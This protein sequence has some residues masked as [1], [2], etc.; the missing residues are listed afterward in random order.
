MP[1]TPL[2]APAHSSIISTQEEH[3]LRQLAVEMAKDIANPPDILKALGFTPVE[4]EE[5]Q[6]TRAYKQMYAEALS[7]WASA[8]NTQ[9]RV[10]LKAAATIELIMHEFYQ[11]LRNRGEN[12]SARTELL[13]TIARIGGLGNP[14]PPQQR[15]SGQFFKLEIHI[16]GKEQPIIIGGEAYELTESPLASEEPYDEL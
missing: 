4:F 8:S 3:R 16:D 15:N 11:D 5:I 10:K 13:K 1:K 2:F 6:Q 9:K 12:L 7:E 14:E